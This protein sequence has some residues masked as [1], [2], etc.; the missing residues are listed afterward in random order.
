MAV[1]EKQKQYAEKYIK[2]NFDE[3]KLRVPKGRKAQIKAF[4]EKQGE[5]VNAFLNRITN[6][7][8]GIKTT[9]DPEAPH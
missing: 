6:E 5:S 3:I 7:A 9:D 8:M 4:A 2:S 1:S